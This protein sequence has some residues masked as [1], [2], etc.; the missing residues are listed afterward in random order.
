[1][2]TLP[3]PCSTLPRTV[4]AFRRIAALGA[5][6]AVLAVPAAAGAQTPGDDQYTDP[7]GG[8]QEQEATPTPTPTPSPEPP[9]AAPAQQPAPTAAPAP[10][11]A[12]QTTTTTAQLPRTGAD[13]GL[14]ALGGALLLVGGVALRVRVSD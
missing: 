8:G 10:A 14:L 1:M 12:S 13:A 11:T 5:A 4:H 2:R 9:A 3:D 7:F 6:A